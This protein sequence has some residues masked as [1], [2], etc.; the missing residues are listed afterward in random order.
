MT[1]RDR[2]FYQFGPFVLDPAERILLK[3]TE[4]VQLAPKAFDILVLLVENRGHL[5]DKEQLMKQVWP[6]S[7][8]EEANLTQ[9]ISVLRRTLGEAKN[10]NIYIETVPRRGYRF[11]APVTSQVG[12][13]IEVAYDERITAH[14]VVVDDG[15]TEDPA[16]VSLPL[17]QA[18]L[19]RVKLSR[20]VVLVG[21]S[22]LLV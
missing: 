19:V 13:V 10:D 5:L 21:V 9:N 6:D 16:A 7:F 14:I 8:V 20:T 18:Q 4:T 11:V 22:C 3:G 2:T 12:N 1:G 15:T 17:V